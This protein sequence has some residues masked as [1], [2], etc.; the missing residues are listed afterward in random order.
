MTNLSDVVITSPATNDILQYN[1]TTSKW[2]NKALGAYN[3]VGSLFT[4]DMCAYQTVSNKYLGADDVVANSDAMQHI[5]PWDCKLVA[6]TFS[7]NT[8][9]V[10]TDLQLK[11]LPWGTG[12]TS[13][14]IYTWP[15]RNTRIARKT[16]FS[17]KI[18][19][20]AGDRIA[21]YALAVSGQTNPAAVNCTLHFMITDDAGGD[22]DTNWTGTTIV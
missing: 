13:T 14:L 7:S 22:D 5:I 3:M 2:E 16:T 6:W 19:F 4:L 1:A 11:M 8:A 20:S 18:T 17:P 12:N 21:L 15:L 9:N 10:G